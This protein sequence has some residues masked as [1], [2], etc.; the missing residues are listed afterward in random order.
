MGDLDTCDEQANASKATPTPTLRMFWRHK[1]FGDLMQ[2]QLE[3]PGA[4]GTHTVIENPVSSPGDIVVDNQCE[5][6]YWSDVQLSKI[7]RVKIDGSAAPE[8]IASMPR[9]LAAFGSYLPVAR[10]NIGA[11]A[12]TA[13]TTLAA[14]VPV[15]RTRMPS[16]T[17]RHARSSSGGGSLPANGMAVHANSTSPH[18][19]GAETSTLYYTWETS[20]TRL[21]TVSLDDL[22]RKSKS[23]RVVSGYGRRFSGFQVTA[24]QPTKGSNGAAHNSTM[25]RHTGTDTDTV[26]T[27]RRRSDSGQ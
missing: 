25:Q 17:A 12:A 3:E 1:I 15:G 7:M 22:A 23:F 18:R 5:Y 21:H 27:L 13:A 4:G 24:G 26:Q 8:R 11:R 16:A 9:P 20:P 6:V 19:L 10:M 2:T 14:G